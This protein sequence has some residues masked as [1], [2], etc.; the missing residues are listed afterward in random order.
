MHV[1]AAHMGKHEFACTN[2]DASYTD[3]RMFSD[4]IIELNV[5]IEQFY[6]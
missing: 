3:Q 6:P 2:C 5:F 4:F 1:Q